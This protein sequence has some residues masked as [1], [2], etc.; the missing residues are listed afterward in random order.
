LTS[1]LRALCES[2]AAI[3]NDP[4]TARPHSQNKLVRR[5]LKVALKAIARISR[6]EIVQI[7][8]L[9]CR[10]NICKLSAVIVGLLKEDKPVEIDKIEARVQSIELV[11]GKSKMPGTAIPKTPL[12]QKKPKPTTEEHQSQQIEETPIESF[13]ANFTA[14]FA[15]LYHETLQS[16]PENMF[17]EINEILEVA[18]KKNLAPNEM[19]KVIFSLDKKLVQ[20]ITDIG[21]LKDKAAKL[22][23]N[24]KLAITKFDDSD[25][26]QQP[27]LAPVLS[28]SS[29]TKEQE[30]PQEQS[31]LV[32]LP[33]GGVPAETGQT[34]CSNS[35]TEML[36]GVKQPFMNRLPLDDAAN[37]NYL[38]FNQLNNKVVELLRNQCQLADQIRLLISNN[39]KILSKI[40]KQDNMFSACLGIQSV[41]QVSS[42]ATSPMKI[43]SPIKS[44]IK[45]PK[46]P[47]ATPNMNLLLGISSSNINDQ[48]YSDTVT[49]TPKNSKRKRSKDTLPHPEISQNSLLAPASPNHKSEMN[50]KETS[51]KPKKAKRTQNIKKS[52][53][54]GLRSKKE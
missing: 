22:R 13:R 46:S 39:E 44:P 11:L 3:K 2:V 53:R 43:A 20:Y 35:T 28:Q 23:E 16:K 32:L 40:G 34:K 49:S 29:S 12:I 50:T 41:P 21:P 27:Q 54:R 48:S 26:S 30:T 45:S 37:K 6:L 15:D 4:S 18:S 17:K 24:L 51:V 5:N 10:D 1:D 42:I 8:P 47:K 33:S 36:P 14:T 19:K 25:H 38:D 7:A 31:T 9:P 52:T